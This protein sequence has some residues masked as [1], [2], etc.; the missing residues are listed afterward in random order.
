MCVLLAGC[1]F[2]VE[3]DLTL[4]GLYLYPEDCFPEVAS[5]PLLGNFC[6]NQWQSTQ[7][8]SRGV[9]KY[10]VGCLSDKFQ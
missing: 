6:G 1:S 2:A 7:C 3:M 4:K 5:Y 10:S 9:P 8:Q